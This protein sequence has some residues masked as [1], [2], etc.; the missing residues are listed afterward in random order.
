MRA[1][2]TALIAAAAFLAGASAYA[3][4]Y[5]AQVRTY[6]ERGMAVHTARG[7]RADG[8]LTDQIVS[9]RMGE[10]KL[11][12]ITLQRG[13]NYRVYAA[14]DADCSDL[15][16]EIYGADGAFVEQDIAL[17]ATPF[18]Q[19]TPSAT[20]AHYVRVWL[21]AC[22][23]EPCFAAVRVVGG[24]EPETRATPA[25]GGGDY[26]AGVTRT[27]N[28]AG[29]AA[30]GAGYALI[31][32]G[33][34]AIEPL[35][36]AGNGQRRSYTLQAGRAY[37]F[38]GACDSDCTDIDIEVTDAR[39]NQ[40]GSNLAVDNPTVLDVTPRAPGEYNVRI[41]LAGCSVEPCFAGMRGYER[42]GR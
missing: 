6:L 7:Y 10:S 29:A 41:W 4:D 16:M 20:G 32:G 19:I 38:I 25:P 11:I 5:P 17:D 31:E 37:R 2:L 26:A 36:L 23:S 14:C 33:D 28:G 24:G 15:D 22:E 27:L 18:I 9:L 1:F 21:A 34:T 13:R 40:I 39:G 3:Q 8:A 42:G 35:T 12:P 30:I